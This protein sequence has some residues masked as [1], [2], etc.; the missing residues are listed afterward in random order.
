MTHIPVIEPGKAT[1]QLEQI[2]QDIR[3]WR[4][5]RVPPPYQGVSLNVKAVEGTVAVN[6][7]V[8]FGQSTLGVRMEEVLGTFVSRL[9][10]CH[11]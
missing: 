11:Y 1:G 8:T 9:N 10:D 6:K 2:Y 5:G 7:A 3:A 4:H